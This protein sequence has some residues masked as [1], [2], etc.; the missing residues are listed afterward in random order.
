Y[1]VNAGINAKAVENFGLLIVAVV[2]A[3]V[4]TVVGAIPF[5]GLVVPNI[6]SMIMGDNTRRS[7]PWVA[8]TGAA[9]CM[10]CDIIGRIIRYPFEIPVGTVMGVVGAA[11]FLTMLLRRNARAR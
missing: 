6:V 2:S 1:A 3:I 4:V 11:I 10:V 5:L 8:V 7:L 9:L